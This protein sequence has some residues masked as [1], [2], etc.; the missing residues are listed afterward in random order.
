[1]IVVRHGVT[2]LPVAFATAILLGLLGISIN[3]AVLGKVSWKVLLWGGSAVSKASVVTV[4][5]LV[6]AS[7]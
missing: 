7:H 1:M 3:E 4:V 5:L 6:G 2:S